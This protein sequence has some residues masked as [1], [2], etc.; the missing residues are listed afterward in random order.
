ME[1][2][3]EYIDQLYEFKGLWDV[4]SLCGL[5]VF[6]KDAKTVF[7][8]TELYDQNPGTSVTN[9]I[10]P[11]AKGLMGEWQCHPNEAI[12]VVQVPDMQSKLNFFRQTFH[13]VDF[14]I[15]DHGEFIARWAEL[16]KSQL[17]ELIH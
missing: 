13:R 8:L 14:T 7:I 16:S 10:G 3:P 4:P 1:L 17:E 15:S 5:Q 2:K 12:V 11:L 9:W 6:K